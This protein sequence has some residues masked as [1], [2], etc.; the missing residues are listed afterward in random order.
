MKAWAGQIGPK[1][2]EVVGE[3]FRRKEHP[4]QAYRSVLGL[5][6]L[7]KRF[8]PERLEKAS[9]RSLEIGSP[10]YRTIFTM[11]KNKM[12]SAPLGSDP[13]GTLDLQSPGVK[14]QTKLAKADHALVRGKG[15]YH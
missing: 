5:I 8:G 11:L 14:A 12:E 3:V 6:R 13:Q 9:I 2:A 10:S 1:T 7:G 4:E 15:Y